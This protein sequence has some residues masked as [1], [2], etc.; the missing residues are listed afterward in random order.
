MVGQKHPRK[1]F[2]FVEAVFTIAIIGI[3]A[4]LAV[5]AISNGARDANR[6]MARQQQA[7][8]Q[9]ALN[10]WVLSQ[11]RVPLE[12]GSTDTA[13][14]QSLEN[15]RT[16]YNNLPSTVAR[17][18][19]LRPTTTGSDPLKQLGFLDATTLA[20][21]DAYTVGS[22]RLKTAALEGARQYLSLPD[23]AP[24]EEP[25]VLLLDE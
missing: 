11:G 9:E 10:A 1:G 22:D 5:S 7:A 17:F 23:W 6:I 4:S 20:H 25:Q 8:V 2:T 16:L 19:K 18:Q 14:V 15:I 24:G 13:Q 21:F 3:M 12:G